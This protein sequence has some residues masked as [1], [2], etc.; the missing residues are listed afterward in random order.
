MQKLTLTSTELIYFQQLDERQK[1]LFAATQALKLGY[2]GVSMVCEAYK[3]NR[4]TVY[5]GKKELA[6]SDGKAT[7]YIRQSGGVKKKCN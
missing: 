4:K 2:Y 1:R 3:I 7:K 6:S 5:K